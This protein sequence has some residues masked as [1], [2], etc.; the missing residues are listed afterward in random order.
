M[1]DSLPLKLLSGCDETAFGLVTNE[2]TNERRREVSSSFLSL[3]RFI[4]SLLSH[5]S[6]E[7]KRRRTTHSPLIGNQHNPLQQ[8][9][10]VQPSLPARRVD[11][12]K[13]GIPDL[14]VLDELV[15]VLLVGRV[16]VFARDEG[17]E[18]GV[19]LRK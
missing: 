5:I 15:N 7:E 16:E 6:K 1:L 14:G 13:N 10:L 11:L 18:V 12:C 2:P 9:H 8:L 17:V 4:F 19:V 3:R